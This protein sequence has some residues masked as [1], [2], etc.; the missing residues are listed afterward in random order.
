MRDVKAWMHENGFTAD[1]L[2]RGIV[3]M[4]P[5]LFRRLL[6]STKLQEEREEEA[7]YTRLQ[8]EGL[9]HGDI[10]EAEMGRNIARF[11]DVA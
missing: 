9:R 11:W 2:R 7:L 1:E 6:R 5:L 10:D 4:D 3:R 8:R